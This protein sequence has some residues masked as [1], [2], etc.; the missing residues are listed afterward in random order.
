MVRETRLRLLQLSS[1]V[2]LPYTDLINTSTILL[3][4]LMKYMTYEVYESVCGTF[5]GLIF[6]LLLLFGMKVK[7]KFSLRIPTTA[8]FV[9]PFV[10]L[11]MFKADQQP[12]NLLPYARIS[13]FLC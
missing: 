7:I 5:D 3:M 11:V 8:P 1:L 2:Q 9:L 12:R 10:L 6:L 13:L 4:C